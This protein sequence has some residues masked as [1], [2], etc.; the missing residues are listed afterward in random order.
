MKLQNLNK[1]DKIETSSKPFLEVVNRETNIPLLSVKFQSIKIT[2]VLE[3][4]QLLHQHS[5]F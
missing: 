2:Q 4:S 1:R 3:Q 5:Y